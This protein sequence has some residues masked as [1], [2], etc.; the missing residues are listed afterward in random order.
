MYFTVTSDKGLI[1]RLENA[2]TL[3]SKIA[4]TGTNELTREDK[5]TIQFIVNEYMGII[6]S[7]QRRRTRN[8]IE[9]RK[10]NR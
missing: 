5:D 10:T 8:A 3:Y 6:Q 7:E 1:S 2:R 4:A 9:A